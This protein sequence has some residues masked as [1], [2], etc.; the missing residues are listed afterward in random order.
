MPRLKRVRLL[1]PR[2]SLICT[3]ALISVLLG[4][5]PTRAAEVGANDFQISAMG[6]ADAAGELSNFSS[7]VA[8]NSTANEYLAVW[9]GDDI[10]PAGT[11]DFEIFGQ[12]L[13]ATTGTKI[14]AQFPI[15]SMG[16]G[17]NQG[18]RDAT[19]PAVA[20]NSFNNEWLVVWEGDNTTDGELDIYSKRIKIGAGGV[21]EPQAQVRISDMGDTTGAYDAVEPDVACN[22]TNG[23]CLIVWSGTDNASGLV[24]TEFEI[25][26]TLLPASG[27]PASTKAYA[28][29]SDMGPD[30][31]G[32]Y[33]AKTPAVSYNGTS[34][35]YL[36]VWSG[37]EFVSSL[38]DPEYEIYGQ[39]VTAAG[40]ATGTNDF[41][42]SDVGLVGET[43]SNRA[44]ADAETP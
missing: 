29:L 38:P 11:G 36:V 28:R 32:A 3:L 23:T 18:A 43:V 12:R 15:S 19:N 42:I 35:Q 13:N 16:S 44:S 9:S 14:G 22:P 4:L 21:T 40:A 5:Q 24:N 34:T 33:N 8:F 39:L 37:N 41:R 31:S 1:T 2:V 6:T 26:R 27:T 10:T 20:Y 25:Y 30:G 7:A 17:A